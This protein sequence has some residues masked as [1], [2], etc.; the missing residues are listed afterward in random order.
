MN[1]IYILTE[2]KTKISV[3]KQLFD[4]YKNDFN[5]NYYIEDEVSI[6]PAFKDNKF[7][8]YYEVYGIKA[9]SI[10][11][12][13]IKIVSGSSSFLDFLFFVS[14]CEPNQDLSDKPLFAV[15]ETKTSDDESRNT[16][17]YQRC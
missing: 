9:S 4:I 2:E 16:G 11:K 6:R 1:N 7:L 3:I 12:I 10:D 15:E 17:V 5:G 8:F 14:D 13:I